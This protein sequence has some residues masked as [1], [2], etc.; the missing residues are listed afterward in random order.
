MRLRTLATTAA[1][2]A[3]LAG[4]LAP[5]AVATG[6]PKGN[7]SCS[8]HLSVAG[9]SDALDKTTVDGRP[10]SG[11]SGLAVDRDGTIAAVSDKSALYSLK[12][13]RGDT[14]KATATKRLPLTDGGGQPLDSEGIVVDRDGSYLAGHG[15][16]RARDPALRPDR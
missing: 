3:A 15:R 2:T 12:V 1:A 13:G 5:P 9:F 8:P 4:M 7:R 16:V 6:A 10:V 14:P 11:I